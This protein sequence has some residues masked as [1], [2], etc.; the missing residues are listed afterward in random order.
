MIEIENE[1]E[2]KLKLFDKQTQQLEQ[3]LNIEVDKW[4]N[5]IKN[6][7]NGIRGNIQKIPEVESDIINYKQLADA[8]IRKYSLMLYKDN[9]SLKPLKKKRFEFY[10]TSYQ[11]K[12]K[13]SSDIKGL[14][15]ADIAKIQYKLDVLEAHI[16]FLRD[17]SS[18]LKTL[19]YSVKNRIELLNILGLD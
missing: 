9:S 11:I 16:N 1:G 5:I 13:N 17:T 4:I 7:S 10:M 18:N 14:V 15:E 6:C 8:D 19:S 2:N 12:L 3:D